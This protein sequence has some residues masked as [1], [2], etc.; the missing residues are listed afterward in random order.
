MGSYVQWSQ[1]QSL[2]RLRGRGLSTLVNKHSLCEVMLRVRVR[3]AK[4]VMGSK[5]ELNDWVRTGGSKGFRNLYFT[6]CSGCLSP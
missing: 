6:S 1:A 3:I 2:V 5:T 4:I